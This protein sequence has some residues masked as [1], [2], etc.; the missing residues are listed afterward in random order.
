MP[1]AEVERIVLALSVA[2]DKFWL[3]GGWGVDALM[4]KQTR[5]HKDLDMCVDI[6]DIGQIKSV[7]EALRYR[8]SKDESPTRVIMKH[9][10]SHRVDIHLLELDEEGNGKQ[11]Y[12]AG[13]HLYPSEDLTDKGLIDKYVVS[14]LSPRLQVKF[15]EAYKPDVKSR[16]D[17]KALLHKYKNINTTI[18]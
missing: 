11:K 6:R 9:G 16:H 3:D 13:F 1:Q 5:N 8:I 4:E 10:N 14:C 12:S 18:I 17:V 7:L 2:G 15:R